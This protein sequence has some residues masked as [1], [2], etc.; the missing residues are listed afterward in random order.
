MRRWEFAVPALLLAA[1][2]GGCS[3]GSMLSSTAAPAQGVYS[4]ALADVF[5]PAVSDPSA[6]NALRHRSVTLQKAGGQIVLRLGA[7]NT[8]H[9]DPVAGGQGRLFAN[10]KPLPRN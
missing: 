7:G 9:L 2:E 5:S 10:E 4:C 3:G 6:P 1:A 8:Q